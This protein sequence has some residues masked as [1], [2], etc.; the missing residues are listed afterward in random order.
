M[1]WFRFGA[2]DM[3][4]EEEEPSKWRR[5]LEGRKAYIFIEKKKILG[6][7]RL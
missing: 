1:E 7:L 2:S 6:Y 5:N 4:I 3:E